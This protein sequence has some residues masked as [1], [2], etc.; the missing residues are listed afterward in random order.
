[1][2]RKDKPRGK[3]IEEKAKKTKLNPSIVAHGNKHGKSLKFSGADLS[4][5]EKAEDLEEG[6]VIGVLENELAGDETGLPPGKYNLFL[7]NISGDWHLYAESNA[8]IIAEATKIKVNKFAA[9]ES[10][11]KEA[12]FSTEGWCLISLCLLEKSD[13]SC[14]VEINACW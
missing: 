13:G 5:L 9:G 12:G 14:I 10:K 3:E 4:Y 1:M 8:E 2:P 11:R 6:E 7:T